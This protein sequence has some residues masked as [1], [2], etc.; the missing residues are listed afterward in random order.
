MIV[1]EK[2]PNTGKKT[3]TQIQEA[4]RVS[5]RINQRRNTP[6]H[7]VIKLTKIKATEKNIKSNKGK[8]TN[9]IKGNSHKVIT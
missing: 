3:V 7:I 1:A 9:Y 5:G 8:V 2:F 4:Q 6:K